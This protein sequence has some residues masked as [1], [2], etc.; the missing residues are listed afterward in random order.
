MKNI[1]KQH[2]IKLDKTCPKTMSGKHRWVTENHRVWGGIFII[3]EEPN[4]YVEC[5]YCG[6]VKE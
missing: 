3:M 4:D 6:I 5:K 2:K 1:D